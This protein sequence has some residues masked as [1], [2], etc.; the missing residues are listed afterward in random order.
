MHS[1]EY[2]IVKY[3]TIT[4]DVNYFFSTINLFVYDPHTSISTEGSNSEADA[5]EN[6]VEMFPQYYNDVIR[7]KSSTTH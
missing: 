3:L 6:I 4:H 1:S 5:S 7:F 2:H